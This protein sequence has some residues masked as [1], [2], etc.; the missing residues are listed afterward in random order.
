MTPAYLLGMS[1]TKE[2]ATLRAFAKHA[3]T[4]AAYRGIL[5]LTATGVEQHAA[6]N[7]RDGYTK[8]EGAANLRVMAAKLQEQ[9]LHTHADV[10]GAGA[11]ILSPTVVPA[12]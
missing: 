11:E 7:T 2:T 12:R 3:A 8:E 6:G 9:G 4:D 10:L 1:P 5:T